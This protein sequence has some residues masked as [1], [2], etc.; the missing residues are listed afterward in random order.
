MLAAFV[1]IMRNY[2]QWVVSSIK[3]KKVAGEFY[4]AIDWIELNYE[5]ISD[6]LNPDE[7]HP[8]LQFSGIIERL[9]EGTKDNESYRDI[10]VAWICE[11]KKVPFGKILKTKAMRKLWKHSNRLSERH[12]EQLIALRDKLKNL[13]YPPSE[14]KWLVRLIEKRR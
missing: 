7:V 12:I 14:M 3:D 5:K 6:L 8:G 9:I 10:I 11:D 2:K 13:E 1:G 4:N